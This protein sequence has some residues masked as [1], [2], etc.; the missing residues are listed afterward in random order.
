M[1]YN[2]RNHNRQSKR[3]R[4]HDYSGQGYYFIT[5]CCYE[6]KH[7]FGYVMKNK[8]IM[9]ESGKIADACWQEIPKH[10][11]NVILHEHV[12][13]PNHIHGIIEIITE[14]TKYIPHETHFDEESPTDIP[15]VG[16]N[17]YSPLRGNNSPLRGNNSPTRRNDST[18]RGNNSPLRGTIRPHGKTIRLYRV[19]FTHTE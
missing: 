2:P 14:S 18:T 4:S 8:M 12:I 7:L 11:P 5:I 9:N 10:F 6:M 1:T 16:A 13:M 3:L 19:Q 17:N 15:P